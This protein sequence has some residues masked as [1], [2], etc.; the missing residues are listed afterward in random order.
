MKNLKLSF[1]PLLVVALLILGCAKESINESIELE[2]NKN[3]LTN[4]LIH[5]DE[6]GETILHITYDTTT[7]EWIEDSLAVRVNFRNKMSSRFTIYSVTGNIMPGCQHTEMWSVDCD[8][9]I[10]YL[11]DKGNGT[12]GN[13]KEGTIKQG[14]GTIS[15]CF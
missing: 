14:G 4:R 2:E 15:S 7:D 10:D 6:N 12:G 1:T 8:E 13:H 11:N 9:Y 3:Q 5:C